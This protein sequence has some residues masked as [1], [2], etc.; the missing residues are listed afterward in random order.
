[1]YNKIMKILGWCYIALAVVLLNTEI[2]I[3]MGIDIVK[4]IIHTIETNGTEW[5][6]M[7]IV[8]IVMMMVLFIIGSYVL[9]K[10]DESEEI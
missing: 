1:M 3:P 4:G 6:L 5:M 10:L 8:T 7:K 9:D 2:L